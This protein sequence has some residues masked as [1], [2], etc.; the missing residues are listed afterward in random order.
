MV[1]ARQIA[2]VFGFCQVEPFWT[3]PHLVP[4]VPCDN[5]VGFPNDWNSSGRDL[6]SVSRKK[7]DHHRFVDLLVEAK[8]LQC[9]VIGCVIQSQWSIVPVM[10]QIGR[11]RVSG[12]SAVMC[13]PLILENERRRMLYKSSSRTTIPLHERIGRSRTF[14]TYIAGGRERKKGTKRPTLENYVVP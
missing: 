8:T 6:F 11:C 10:V 5:V 7:R 13:C 3:S 14:S 12:D 4:V 1:E 9:R 2:R